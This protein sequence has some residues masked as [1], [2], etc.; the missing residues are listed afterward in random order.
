LGQIVPGKENQNP[1][2]GGISPNFLNQ[3]I[4]VAL[5]GEQK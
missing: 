1:G 5:F 2:V 3:H 4:L